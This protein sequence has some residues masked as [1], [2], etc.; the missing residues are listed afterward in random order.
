MK[1]SLLPFIFLFFVCNIKAQNCFDGFLKEGIRF[2]YKQNFEAAKRLFVASNECA[3]KD[4]AQ[5]TEWIQRVTYAENIFKDSL[6]RIYNNHW[7]VAEK[8]FDAKNYMEALS[9]YQKA[10]D[11]SSKNNIVKFKDKDSL[12]NQKIG[13]CKLEL[14]R[15]KQDLKLQFEEHIRQGNFLYSKR[16][17]IRAY[18]SYL[19]AYKNPTDTA[20][21]LSKLHRI[22]TELKK[23]PH[24]L[25]F[26]NGIK[27]QKWGIGYVTDV[28]YM[29]NSSP[30][31]RGEELTFSNR[32]TNLN[33]FYKDDK[34]LLI[35]PNKKK[36]HRKM[37]A[38]KLEVDYHIYKKWIMSANVG[39]YVR[40]ADTLYEF[41]KHPILNDTFF[42][43]SAYPNNRGYSI[44]MGFKY[45][46][47]S[48]QKSFA[49]TKININYI[50]WT[51]AS[52][53]ILKT[54]S[55]TLRYVKVDNRDEYYFVGEERNS[56]IYVDN[57]RKG[58]LMI[59]F[60]IDYDVGYRAISFYSY[61]GYSFELL[62]INK[63]GIYPFQNEWDDGVNGWRRSAYRNT[64]Y[65]GSY[66]TFG[67]ALVWNISDAVF[68]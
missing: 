31:I 65:R 51:K 42:V 10:I 22:E 12:A 30:I 2:Y 14:E 6:A 48:S 23:N 24:Y 64:P 18:T 45:K 46:I 16:K 8:A 68:R 32:Y 13:I 15:I 66:L 38:R 40:L 4:E 36:L 20:I 33:R 50:N 59:S 26:S 41:S 49:S 62:N 67:V 7:F 11:I 34:S 9:D 27:Y 52:T 25:V 53:Q 63:G 58:N 29:F 44:G 1:R 35:M 5:I 39:T 54:I 17:Y 28:Y 57:L 19:N 37:F 43:S 21:A 60:L 47:F 3:D 61:L 56:K 55:D